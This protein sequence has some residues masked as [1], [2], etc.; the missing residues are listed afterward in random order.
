MRTGRSEEKWPN[1]D[2]A[3][4]LNGS[5]PSSQSRYCCFSAS[6][7]FC[8]FSYRELLSL[9]VPAVMRSLRGLAAISGRIKLRIDPVSIKT[10]T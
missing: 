3:S 2:L 1:H 9:A 10:F 4:E 7:R 8:C 6:Y 5:E